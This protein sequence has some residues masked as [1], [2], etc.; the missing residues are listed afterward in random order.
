[1]TG[2][3]ATASG[4][5]SIKVLRLE[6]SASESPSVTVVAHA[7]EPHDHHDVN[8]VA[9]CPVEEYQHYLASAG[10]DG[11]VRIWCYEQEGQE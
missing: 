5:N 11:I 8:F 1:N 3:I 9:W 4:D 6:T 2:L 7:A 10:D